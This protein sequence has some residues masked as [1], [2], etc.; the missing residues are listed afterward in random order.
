MP[1]FQVPRRFVEMPSDAVPLAATGKL[2]RRKIAQLYFHNVQRDA[3]GGA[4]DLGRRCLT[5][6]DMRLTSTETR[7]LA[8]WAQL[9]THVP[10]HELNA[11]SHFFE[12]GGTSALA[13]QMVQRLS[14]TRD[15]RDQHAQLCGLIN[16]PRLRDYCLFLDARFS[17]EGSGATSS[18]TTGRTTG[19]TIGRQALLLSTEMS[20]R[21]QPFG[22]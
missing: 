6:T 2:D 13:V 17:D 22:F 18:T 7:V 20:H 19:R 11:R 16:H 8:V 21:N 10:R 3:D 4:K 5:S 9:F 14:G 15:L 12:L 1:R